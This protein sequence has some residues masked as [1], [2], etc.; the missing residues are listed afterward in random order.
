MVWI[1][2]HSETL[3]RVIYRRIRIKHSL[4]FNPNPNTGNKS[5]T[6]KPLFQMS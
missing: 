2:R 5:L 3:I 4:G 1:S 6:F